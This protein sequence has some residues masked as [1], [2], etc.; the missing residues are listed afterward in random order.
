M[1]EILDWVI[2][3]AC[4]FLI[5]FLLVH[6]V[7]QKLDVNGSSMVP[8]LENGEQVLMDKIS[9]RFHEPERYD[10]VVFPYQ[11]KEDT[12]FIKRVI[13]LPGETVQINSLGQILIDGEPIED[14]YAKEIT[15]YAG[16]AAVPITLGDDE[17]FVLGDNRNVSEDSRYPDVGNIKREAIMG[18][19]WLRIWPLKAF[20][21]VTK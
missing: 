13:G 15:L 16:V 19:A 17:Y 5:S 6:F 8:T 21:L 14:P 7:I 12:Y 4:V 20:G 11:Y 18:R 1:R 10:I 2:W 9:Y 3:A